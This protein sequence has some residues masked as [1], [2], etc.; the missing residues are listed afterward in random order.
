M[1]I[2]INSHSWVVAHLCIS[3]KFLF[4]LSN[5]TQAFFFLFWSAWLDIFLNKV[6][7]QK[8]SVSNPVFYIMFWSR[9]LSLGHMAMLWSK[10]MVVSRSSTHPGWQPHNHGLVEQ[11]HKVPRIHPLKWVFQKKIWVTYWHSKYYIPLLCTFSTPPLDYS[12]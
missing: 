9:S 4:F 7:A 8:D 10:L 2:R 12:C 6:W 5:C 1:N 11:G 3:F